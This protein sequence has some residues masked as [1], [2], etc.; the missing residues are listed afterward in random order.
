MTAAL[1]SEELQQFAGMSAS[2]FVLHREPML[3]LDRLIDIGVEFATCEWSSSD[4]FALFVPGLGVPAYAGIEYMAQC[5]AVHAGARARA[6][7]LVPPH[8]YLLGTRHY[9]CSVSYF[10]SGV[11]YQVTCQEL[12]RDSQGMGSFTCR[13]LLNGSSIAEANLAVLEIPQEIKLN[14]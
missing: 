2:A 10:D 13:I 4:D 5:V 9:Q 8:G 14:D 11:T 6:R 12:V 3:F 1:T 7:G